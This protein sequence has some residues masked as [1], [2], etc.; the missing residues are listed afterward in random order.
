MPAL[1]LAA[2]EGLVLY[3][4]AELVARRMAGAAMREPFGEIGTAVPLGAA[5]GVGLEDAALEVAR[6]PDADAR[7]RQR[8]GI[9]P[10]LLAHRLAR[11]DEGIERG[12]VLVR[13]LGEMVVGKRREEMAAF[14]VDAF[15]HRARKGLE[16]PAADAGFGVRGDVGAIDGAERRLER[17]AAGIGLAAFRGM[18]AQ[19]VADMGELLALGDLL[20]RERFGGVALGDAFARRAADRDREQSQDSEHAQ[21]HLHRLAPMYSR[22]QR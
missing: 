7:P 21:G 11:H 17:R 2:R 15:A 6:L 12:E 19:A 9:A 13:Q 20:A 4:R 14:A 5:R 8:H 1:D 18:A 3:F 16:R 22:L 10:V